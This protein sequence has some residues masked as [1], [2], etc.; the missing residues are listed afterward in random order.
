LLGKFGGNT[1][2]SPRF[3]KHPDRATVD[4]CGKRL[5]NPGGRRAAELIRR[6]PARKQRRRAL[7]VRQKT[8]FRDA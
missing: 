2:N 8:I 6:A 4:R 7:Y 5:L 3:H 1:H